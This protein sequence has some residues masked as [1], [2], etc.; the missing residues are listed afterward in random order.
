MRRSCRRARP[1]A[2]DLGH[3][4][5]SSGPCCGRSGWALALPSFV[6]GDSAVFD[7]GAEEYESP[8][9]AEWC[10]TTARTG[11]EE[12]L[13]VCSAGRKVIR[14]IRQG[15]I[16]SLRSAPQCYR[17]SLRRRSSRAVS[18]WISRHGPIVMILEDSTNSAIGSPTR[19]TT[20]AT[21]STGRC[22]FGGSMPVR[23]SCWSC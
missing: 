9:T 6:R 17:Q 20:P 15:G 16:V 5:L 11:S 13:Q 3:L 1:C 14:E 21:R 7:E 10:G 22:P 4:A 2:I 23:H 18:T 8:A 19:S 12:I